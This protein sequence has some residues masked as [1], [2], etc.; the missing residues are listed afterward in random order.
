MDWLD[1]ASAQLAMAGLEEQRGIW[2]DLDNQV[3]A[4]PTA[5]G[6]FVGWLDVEWPTTT[7]P[8]RALRGVVHVPPPAAE[9][10]LAA[11]LRRAHSRLKAAL[12]TCRYCQE[13]FTPGHMHA[14]DVCQGCAER[15]LGVLH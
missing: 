4:V 12:R 3:G 10:K 11:A 7:Q 13:R 8:V 6:I 9:P 14:A 1:E 5:V 2:V 15:E